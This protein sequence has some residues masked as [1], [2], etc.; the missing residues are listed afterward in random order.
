MSV[1]PTFSLCLPVVLA[2]AARVSLVSLGTS[3]L[4]ALPSTLVPRPISESRTAVAISLSVCVRA[5]ARVWAPARGGRA[6]PGT[7]WRRNTHRRVERV[8]HEQ[9]GPLHRHLRHS[10]KRLHGSVRGHLEVVQHAR[11]RA[12]GAQAAQVPLQRLHSAL[13][14]LL[15]DIHVHNVLKRL[16]IC[17]CVAALTPHV[18]HARARRAAGARG[19]TRLRFLR[20]YARKAVCGACRRR[21]S[22]SALGP[23]QGPRPKPYRSCG[24]HGSGGLLHPPLST[25]PSRPLRR[26]AAL[27]TA[28][29]ACGRASG[30]G[31]PEK[32]MDGGRV[33]TRQAQCPFATQTCRLRP[34]AR[35]RAPTES[36]WRILATGFALMA[37]V[38]PC[39]AEAATRLVARPGGRVWPAPGPDDAALPA[40]SLDDDVMDVGGELVRVP[41]EVL[42]FAREASEPA[43]EPGRASVH[44]PNV[45]C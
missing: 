44:R 22:V 40:Q 36:A 38:G 19:R 33:G 28:A 2:M 45:R 30:G 10:R 4:T 20:P 42:A 9:G 18:C 34:L 5:I 24:E 39:R 43:S 3:T 26:A 16:D 14:P 6:W 15:D 17:S 31:N 11:V 8:H 7:A 32:G 12:P 25:H 13:Q 29:S 23:E 21:K 1:A 37:C 35:A 41:A 27:F